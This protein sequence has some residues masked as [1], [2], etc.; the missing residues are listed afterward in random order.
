MSKESQQDRAL[1]ARHARVRLLNEE[2]DRLTTDVGERSVS[3][4]SKASFLAV[5]AGVLVAASTSQI[6]ST[7]AWFG[8]AALVFAGVAVLCAAVA[9]RP[10]RRLGLVAQRLT[11]RYLDTNKTA[12]AIET[13]IVQGKSRAI[14]S[15]EA[16]L[17]TRATWVWCGFGALVLSTASLA[18]V[19]AAQL[20]GG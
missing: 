2:L 12:L 9:L 5:S 6:W 17:V 15:R 19:F 1:R 7:Q 11:D 16:D 20:L 10:A 8:I 4:T 13:E 14:T 3:V 18:T